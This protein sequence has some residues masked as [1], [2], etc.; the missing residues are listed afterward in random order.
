VAAAALTW[1]AAVGVQRAAVG[2]VRQASAQVGRLAGRLR[3][4]QE[5]RGQIENG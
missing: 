3:L 4:L 1:C 2:E 5:V